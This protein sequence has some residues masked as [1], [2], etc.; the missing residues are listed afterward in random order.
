MNPVTA[1]AAA[2][3]YDK[4]QYR[5]AAHR[6]TAVNQ[7]PSLIGALDQAFLNAHQL[8]QYLEIAVRLP[9]EP[10]REKDAADMLDLIHTHLQAAADSFH[11]VAQMH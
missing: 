7:Q 11:R 8:C 1:H 9:A 5:A 4:Q 2:R 10:G 6:R 3:R